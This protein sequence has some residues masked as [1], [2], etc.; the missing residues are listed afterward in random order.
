MIRY[1]LIAA[2]CLAAF[3]VHMEA[4]EDPPKLL[5]VAKLGDLL[6]MPDRKALGVES[7]DSY[8]HSV[9]VY[10]RTA[11][12]L[13]KVE[14]PSDGQPFYV[15]V[16]QPQI[17]IG[18]KR[19]WQMVLGATAVGRFA[20]GA[21]YVDTAPGDL[22]EG[23]FFQQRPASPPIKMF[24]HND[25]Q[26]FRFIRERFPVYDAPSPKRFNTTAQLTIPLPE[27]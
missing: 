12:R 1:S 3:G 18:Q 20:N 22:A 16:E 19:V 8:R 5:V 23:T 17:H 10:S 27:L 14:L 6:I 26:N 9:S 21:G 7:L 15:A 11:R 4:A 2:S 25:F 13:A 24:L